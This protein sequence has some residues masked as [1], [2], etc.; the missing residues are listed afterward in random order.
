M[1][2]VDGFTLDDTD[3]AGSSGD[4]PQARRR[5]AGA[6]AGGGA[7][8]RPRRAR[9][10]GSSRR[11]FSGSDERSAHRP[12]AS[13]D[14][15]RDPRLELSAA[16]GSR[17]HGAASPRS[18]RWRF[19]ARSRRRRRSRRSASSEIVDHV[20]EPRRQIAGRRRS[21]RRLSALPSTRYH[22]PVQSRQA[23]ELRRT[24]TKSPVV[25]P[26]II[27]LCSRTPKPRAS[28]GRKP[29]GW[30]FTVGISIMCGLVSIGRF[31]PRVTRG[32]VWR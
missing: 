24:S 6:R 11:S 27:V 20:R 16:F 15:R 25:T 26:N 12:A 5:A 31:L 4:L 3:V 19:P 7:H 30:P 2:A 29:S 1:A 32:S 17:T 21:S 10:G 8:R 23:E 14:A 28:R 13:S 18:V 22:A 9:T